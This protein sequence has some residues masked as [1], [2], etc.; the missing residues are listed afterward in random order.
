MI[1]ELIF[2]PIHLIR[3]QQKSND[4]EYTTKYHLD[5]IFLVHPLNLSNTYYYFLTS[6]NHHRSRVGLL[7]ANS[8]K[9]RY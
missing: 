1:I 8:I 2:Y 7:R 6:V 5:T 3:F 9:L 4:Q